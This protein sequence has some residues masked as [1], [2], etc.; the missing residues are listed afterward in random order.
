MGDQ[1]AAL[2]F[3]SNTMDWLGVCSHRI[4]DQSSYI[5]ISL[6]HHLYVVVVE[7]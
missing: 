7:D 1:G 4:K 6:H 5:E 3:Q 2:H